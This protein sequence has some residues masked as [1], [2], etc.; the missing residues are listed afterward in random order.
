M[1]RRNLR[2]VI[3]AKY[4]TQAVFSFRAKPEK[5]I[6]AHDCQI[7]ILVIL[8]SITGFALN[9]FTIVGLTIGNAGSTQQG[10]SRTSQAGTPP[11]EE[12]RTATSLPIRIKLKPEL[13]ITIESLS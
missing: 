8:L 13:I 11:V 7:S 10:L 1:I 5:R 3:G 12:R 4:V 9:S 6:Q 2:S